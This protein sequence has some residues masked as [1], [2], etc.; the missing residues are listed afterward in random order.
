MPTLL[1]ACA[2]ASCSIAGEQAKM[3]KLG[4]PLK[5][6]H[7]TKDARTLTSHRLRYHTA[8]LYKPRMSLPLASDMP[9]AFHTLIPAT[10]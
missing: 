9:S 10:A 6:N 3:N 8:F 1:A 5:G 4:G 2:S 7:I